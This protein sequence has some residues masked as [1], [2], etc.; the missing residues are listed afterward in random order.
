MSDVMNKLHQGSLVLFSR[1]QRGA[2]RCSV[3]KLRDIKNYWGGREIAGS[4]RGLRG[5]VRAWH[6]TVSVQP[7]VTPR[8][9]HLLGAP[10]ILPVS[11]SRSVGSCCCSV[12]EA[13][14]AKCC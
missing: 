13:P 9:S 14:S 7:A 10:G 3:D 11:R 4:H 2:E 8:L 6:G 12:L 1:V 5:V